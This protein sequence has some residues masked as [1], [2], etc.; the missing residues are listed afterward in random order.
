MKRFRLLVVLVSAFVLLGGRPRASADEF[1]AVDHRRQS[2][3]H[4]PQ[5][6]GFT[7]WIG[8][9]TMP[10]GSLMTCFAQAT[11]PIDGRPQASDV[12]RHKLTWP[13]KGA[14]GYDMTGLDLK[15]V[16]LRSTDAGP[17]CKQ[18]SG[19]VLRVDRV[20]VGRQDVNVHRA[21]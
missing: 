7:S 17:T 19:D 14:P 15:N 2:I 6:P 20:P 18:V 13:P 21:G 11:G 9:W 10:D 1:S 16:H 3:Y 5:T 8:A 12:V 4:L